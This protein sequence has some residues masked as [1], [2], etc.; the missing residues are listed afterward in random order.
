MI[1][2]MAHQQLELFA[3][4]HGTIAAG[5]PEEEIALCPAELADDALITVLPEAGL[6]TAPAL[7][8]EI[9][10]RRLA[11]AV[12]PLER[13]CRRLVG[14]GAEKIVPEQATALQALEAIGGAVARK[15]IV[16]TIVD[17]IVQGPTLAIALAAAARLAAFLPASC[18]GEL[19]RHPDPAIRARACRC[20]PPAPSLVEPLTELLDD[21]NRDVAFAAI[22][23]L[24]RIGRVEARPLLIQLLR[25]QPSAEAIDAVAEIADEEVVVLLG[26]IAREMPHLAVSALDALERIDHPRGSSRDIRAGRLGPVGGRLPQPDTISS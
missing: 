5:R 9:G 26:R 2:G 11:D 21:L 13:L 25:R 7:A 20:V 1:E 16:R 8:A 3:T 19:L 17:R 4:D 23:A 18:V 12:Q 6:G 22:C 10:R 14:F 24:G 15:A